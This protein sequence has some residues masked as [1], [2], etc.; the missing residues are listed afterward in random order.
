M[1]RKVFYWKQSVQKS[2]ICALT[3]GRE[4][5]QQLLGWFVKSASLGRPVKAR[6]DEHGMCMW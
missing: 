6:F 2:T 3:Y 4:L 1:R 5:V